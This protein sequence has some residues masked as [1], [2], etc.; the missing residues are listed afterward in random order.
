VSLALDANGDG[1]PDLFT[2]AEETVD[3]PSLSRLW[4]N[5]GDRFELQEGPLVNDLGNL[6]AAA[7]DIDGDGLDELAI[8]TPRDGFRLYRNEGSAYVEA[9]AELGLE[10]F[11][12]RAAE[13][14]DLDDDGR[15]DLV[16]VT[17][18]TVQAFLNDGDGYSKAAFN[19]KASDAT[20]VAFGDVDGDGDLDLYV[21]EGGGT[22]EPDRIY[23]NDGDGRS[24][25]RG[26]SVPVSS[27]GA[28]DAVQTIPDW[29]DSGR[30]AFL[31]NNGALD[32][33]GPRQLITVSES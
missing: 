9:T 32:A 19:V 1:R 20:D 22:T 15:P 28:G 16:T 25:T 7:A 17:K 26:P 12:R 24:F 27:S 31:V 3:F 30:D 14:V 6:C 8:C 10:T 23:L 11:G 2:G 4:I 33:P 21:Q 29:R 5:Q 13:F 18:T